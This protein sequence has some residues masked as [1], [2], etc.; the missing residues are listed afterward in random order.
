MNQILVNE[1]VV[2][3]NIS[4][5]MYLLSLTVPNKAVVSVL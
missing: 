2:L 1:Q 4:S 3:L 5:K